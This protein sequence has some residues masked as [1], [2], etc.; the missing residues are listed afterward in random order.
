M[1]ALVGQAIVDTYDEYEQLASFHI[2]I[3]ERL[4]DPPLDK[5]LREVTQR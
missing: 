1:G 4:A 5:S 2:V 3:K